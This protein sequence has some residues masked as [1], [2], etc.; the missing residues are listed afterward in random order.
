MTE[1]VGLFSG[2]KDSMVA[3]LEA[4]VKEVVYCRTGVGLNEEYVV[5]TCKRF[6]WKLH[7]VEPK[8]GET[9]EDFVRR[10]GFPHQGIHNTIMG[11][12]KWHPMR[13]WYSTQKK[14][15]RDIIY[16]SGRRKKESARRKRMK[17][18]KEYLEM[19]G[20]KFYSPIFDWSTGEVWVYLE[21]HNID[22]SPI[23]ETMHL[24]GDCMCGAFSQKGESGI[25]SI[26]HPEMAKRFRR[27]EAEYGGKWGNQISMTDMEKQ[28]NLE[29]WMDALTEAGI[30][31]DLICQ[32]CTV[33]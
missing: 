20:I 8:E 3:C 10:F 22:R 21:E 12:L 19:D 18:N 17:S 26:F 6:G 5:K 15:G 29:I 28:Q 16:I 27:M 2:G 31:D 7:I 11:M 13:K 33:E 9:Y 24:S 30:G 25:L 23:Y 4:G 32:E 1:Y 14:L